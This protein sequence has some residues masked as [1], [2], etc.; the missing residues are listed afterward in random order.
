MITPPGRRRQYWK[1]LHH[2]S[3]RRGNVGQVFYFFNFTCAWRRKASEPALHPFR[4]IIRDTD[5]L[6]SAVCDLYSNSG[7]T[8]VMAFSTSSFT[9]EEGRSTTSPAAIL[10]MVSVLKLQF[11]S[12]VSP[13]VLNFVLQVIENIQSFHWCQIPNLQVFDLFND[14][15]VLYRGTNS[16]ICAIST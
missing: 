6:F 3:Q 5:Q 2:G 7:S 14:I 4:S 9:T 10:S 13:P 11:F 15:I 12:R 8:C 16:D 1:V